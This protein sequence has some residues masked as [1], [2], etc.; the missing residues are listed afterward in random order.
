MSE[1]KTKQELNISLYLSIEEPFNPQVF[2]I[3]SKI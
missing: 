3:F 1:A 2:D